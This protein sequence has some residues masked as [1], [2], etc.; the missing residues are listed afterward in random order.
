MHKLKHFRSLYFVSQKS[1]T[2]EYKCSVVVTEE[3][4]KAIIMLPDP[5]EHTSALE[6][7]YGEYI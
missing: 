2:P 7:Y 4:E 5:H 6:T 1:S 3:A